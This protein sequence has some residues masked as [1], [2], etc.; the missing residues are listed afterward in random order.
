MTRRK[1][2]STSS[3]LLTYQLRRRDDVL[4][5]SGTFKLASKMGQFLGGTSQYT[6]TASQVVQ[7]LLGL[8]DV[9][10]WSVSL[11]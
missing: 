3:V 2:V 4:A 11:T 5:W 8:C 10:N 6:F 7:S 1:E 9:L